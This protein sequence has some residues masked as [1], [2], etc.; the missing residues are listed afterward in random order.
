MLDYLKAEA[1]RRGCS[2]REVLEAM[3]L[4]EMT[5]ALPDGT[6]LPIEKTHD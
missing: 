6:Q 5:R 3:I 1:Q 4:A 2:Q